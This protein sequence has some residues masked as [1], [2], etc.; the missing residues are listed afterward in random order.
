MCNDI[1]NLSHTFELRNGE[2]HSAILHNSNAHVS[3]C[4]TSIQLNLRRQFLAQRWAPW[5]ATAAGCIRQGRGRTPAATTKS[6]PAMPRWCLWGA[7]RTAVRSVAGE[8]VR[9]S[10]HVP[11]RAAWLIDRRAHL[12]SFEPRSLG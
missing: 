6:C 2:S 12:H 4:N 11:R 8:A 7:P 5:A 1:Y 10:R 9:L 3:N